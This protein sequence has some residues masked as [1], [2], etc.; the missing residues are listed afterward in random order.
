MEAKFT[1]EIPYSTRNKYIDFVKEVNGLAD[2]LVVLFTCNIPYNLK[3]YL[4]IET[5]KHSDEIKQLISSLH[6]KINNELG[7]MEL[8]FEAS[9]NRQY[10]HFSI[11]KDNSGDIIDTVYQIT[12]KMQESGLNIWIDKQDI[13]IGDDIA[14][15][16]LGGIRESD[17]ALLF[18]SESTLKSNFAQFELSHIMNEM[19]R[20]KVGW[21]IVRLDQVDPEQISPG[22]G[23]YLYI[24]YNGNVEKLIGDV[25]KKLVSLKC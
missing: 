22:F 20:K 15:K 18:I 24:D 13:D 3:A 2:G 23:N 17:L 1:V 12:D 7:F 4:V 16:V 11:P 6:L 10:K 8:L 19:L 14:Q 21:G 25:Q 9:S 5:A